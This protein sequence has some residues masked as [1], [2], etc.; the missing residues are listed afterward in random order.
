MMGFT[1][2]P[3]W[4]L[5]M[6]CRGDTVDM[7]M[8]Y[9]SLKVE[10]IITALAE[11]ELHHGGARRE[12]I[13][14]GFTS[15]LRESVERQTGWLVRVGPICI[16]ELPLFLGDDWEVPPNLDLGKDGRS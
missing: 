9:K 4:L 1:L 13:L 7:A 5:L 11:S 8:V 16:A 12:I 14:P 15:Q 6:D 10:E 3:F 2:S